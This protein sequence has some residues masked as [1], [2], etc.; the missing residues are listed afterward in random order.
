MTVVHRTIVI[1]KFCFKMSLEQGGDGTAFERIATD[2]QRGVGRL[3]EVDDEVAE[4]PEIGNRRVIFNRDAHLDRRDKS[5]DFFVRLA[6]LMRLKRGAEA[7]ITGARKIME[8]E[9]RPVA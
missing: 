9:G 7:I 8:R 2:N 3:V 6:F 5:A 4:R 1:R